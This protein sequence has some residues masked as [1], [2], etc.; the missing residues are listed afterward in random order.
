M[1]VS[2]YQCYHLLSDFQLESSCMFVSEIGPQITLLL[3]EFVTIGSLESHSGYV[4]GSHESQSRYIVGSLVA[5]C[6][7]IVGSLWLPT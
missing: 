4:Y 1:S 3:P 2:K 6:R 5:S 7:Y